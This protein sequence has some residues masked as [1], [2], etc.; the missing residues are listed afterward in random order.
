MLQVVHYD[1]AVF[2]EDGESNKQ[3]EITAEVIRP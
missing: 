2:L 1:V 3:V